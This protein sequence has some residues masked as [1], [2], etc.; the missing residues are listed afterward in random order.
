M[1]DQ[2]NVH[3]DSAIRRSNT[4]WIIA[5]VVG[6]VV[7]GLVAFRFGGFDE[8]GGNISQSTNPTNAPGTTKKTP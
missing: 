3:D 2:G 4:T 5:V 8:Q 7:L 1:A 6:F